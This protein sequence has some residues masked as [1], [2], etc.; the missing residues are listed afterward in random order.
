MLPSENINEMFYPMTADLYYS[1]GEQNDFGEMVS[2]W[3]KDRTIKCSAIKE[4]PS[5]TVQNK[6][7]SQKFI[8]YEFRLDFRTNEDVLVAS[9]GTSYALTEIIITNIKDPSGKVVWFESSSQATVFELGNV[10]PMF[11]PFHNYFGA[12]I[13]LRRADDQYCIQ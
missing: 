10:E 13:L 9:D 6:I 7:T 1:S 3:T 5:T 4:R 2:T 8:E 12:R 11:D